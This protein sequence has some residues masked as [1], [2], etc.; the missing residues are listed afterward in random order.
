MYI[1]S[2]DFREKGCIQAL[3]E[4]GLEWGL[5]PVTWNGVQVQLKVESLPVGDFV[6]LEDHDEK[7]FIE[8]KTKADLI[9]SV[10]DG[11]FR[12]QKQRL[13]ATQKEIVYVVEQSTSNAR[14]TPQL[15]NVYV[16]SL[17]NLPFKHAIKVIPSANEKETVDILLTLLRKLSQK[18]LT[19]TKGSS[20]PVVVKQTKGQAISDNIFALQLSLIKGVTVATAQ[21]IVE[22]YKTPMDLIKAYENAPSAKEK[23]DLL[24]DL[25]TS[26]KRRL[27]PVVSKRIYETFCGTQP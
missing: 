20:S 26:N 2:I 9:S 15:Q 5:E 7:I 17:V 4:R 6:L 21:R 24:Q 25:V 27:G 12:D 16:S 23:Q 11:R 22:M 18:D 8:R 3:K 1:L 10:I 19:D 13:L 14:V